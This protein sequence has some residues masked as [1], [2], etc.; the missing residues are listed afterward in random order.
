M[1][2]VIAR[3]M[4]A[5]TTLATAF[6]LDVPASYAFGD[7]PWCAVKNIGKGDYWDCEY[8][9]FEAYY[10]NALADRGGCYLNPRPGPTTSTTAAYPRHKKHYVQQH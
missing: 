9:T 10:P 5:A 4:C 7:A 3:L 8:R 6:C 1:V 2:K